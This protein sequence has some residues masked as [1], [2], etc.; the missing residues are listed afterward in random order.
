MNI[1]TLYSEFQDDPL[2]LLNALGGCY[3]RPPGGPL[4]GYAG[5]YSSE[6][7]DL[8]F[9]GELYANFAKAERFPAVITRWARKILA[10]NQYALASADVFLGAPEGG[11]SL[12]DKFAM[13]V[14]CEYVYPDIVETPVAG[15]R[16]KKDF[17]WGRHELESGKSVVIVED[18]ANNFST[19]A[20]LMKL[21]MD[22]GCTPV[23]LVCLLNRSSTVDDEFTCE[24]GKIP[25]LSLVRMPMPE[26]RQ[27]GACVA[28]DIASGNIVWKPRATQ[29]G[30]QRLMDAMAEA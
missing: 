17:K 24:Y 6:G 9:V 10:K 28:H 2:G 8:N 22:A 1:R 21:V 4:V 12:A 19:T 18:V 27:D 14:A 5:T 29:E 23:A 30:W 15:G 11:K 3:L 13:H 26:Y 7:K 25:V 20:K 16:P